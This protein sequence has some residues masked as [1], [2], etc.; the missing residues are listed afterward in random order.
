MCDI[1]KI[2]I[3]SEDEQ[4]LFGLIKKHNLETGSTLAEKIIN[5]W[6]D[7]LD[8]FKKVLPKAYA[9]ALKELNKKHTV[10]VTLDG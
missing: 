5:N 8:K 6:G 7:Y 9:R 3:N 2:S 1:E 10:K 4:I